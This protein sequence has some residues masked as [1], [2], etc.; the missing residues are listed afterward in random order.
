MVQSET[1]CGVSGSAVCFGNAPP[2]NS[3]ES[4]LVQEL[5][6]DLEEIILLTS[7][8]LLSKPPWVIVEQVLDSMLH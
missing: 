2:Q 8:L 1:G 4:P 3:V 5:A 6:W 7:V